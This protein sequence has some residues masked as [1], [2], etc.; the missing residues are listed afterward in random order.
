[1]PGDIR[2]PE[3]VEITVAAPCLTGPGI[4]GHTQTRSRDRDEITEQYYLI[5]GAHG[6]FRISDCGLRIADYGMGPVTQK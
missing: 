3:T 2:F 6:G 5:Y 1:M 4:A